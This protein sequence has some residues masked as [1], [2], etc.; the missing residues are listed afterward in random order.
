MNRNTKKIVSREVLVFLGLIVL[1]TL[2]FLIN[3]LPRFSS[4]HLKWDI[5]VGVLTG[6][7][8][9][10]VAYLGIRFVIWL[11]KSFRGGK[12]QGQKLRE[13]YN[14]LTIQGLLKI[15][16]ILLI[17]H[18]V[19]SFFRPIQVRI[20]HVSSRSDWLDLDLDL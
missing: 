13:R 6:T 14:K 3:L 11:V 9:V 4:G 1:G 8:L 10:Y 12:L 18:L 17:I 19:I 2:W 7:F 16:L 20:I 15:V 5:F